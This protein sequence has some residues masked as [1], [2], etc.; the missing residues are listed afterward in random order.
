MMILRKA[1]R[2]RLEPTPEQ[3]SLLARAAGCVRFVWNRA[4][5]IQ[6][7]YL[8]QGCGILSYSEMC[9]LL[10]AWRNSE[11]FGFLAESPSHPQ[12]QTLRH[13]AR[14]LK[15]AFDKTS[16]K[17]FPIFKKKFQRDSI[18]YPNPDHIQ[19]HL[20]PKDADGR[21]VLPTIFLPRIGWVKFRKSRIIGGE[22]RN[23]T[24][25]RDCGHWFI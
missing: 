21:N 11:A 23:V 6:K 15:D 14:A 18:R 3:E 19:F 25:S 4:L 5:A 10:T 9:H 16:E 17:E 24:V 13:L 12:Q 22:I 20:R 2:Y 7:S 8:D 1:V